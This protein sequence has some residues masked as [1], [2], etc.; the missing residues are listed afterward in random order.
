M[1]RLGHS[2]KQEAPRHRWRLAAREGS[3]AGTGKPSMVA[4]AAL[5]VGCGLAALA[6]TVAMAQ[7]PFMIPNFNFG[8]QHYRGGSQH[9]STR[10]S[11]HEED[12]APDKTAPA[13][14]KSKERDATE[15]TASTSA[16]RQQQQTTSAPVSHD[17]APS[18]GS[19][20]PASPPPAT[21]AKQNNDDQPA[22]A[23]SR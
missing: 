5:V 22:F 17:A 11:R 19:G 1:L 20:T 10:H 21:P 9:Y 15:P 2:S 14:D 3:M 16:P 4:A 23:P 18:G 7:I 12:K 13:P 6:P 8:P